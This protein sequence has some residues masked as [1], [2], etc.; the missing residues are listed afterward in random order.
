M[1]QDNIPTCHGTSPHAV[2]SWYVSFTTHASTCGFYV[3]PYFCFCPSTPSLMGFTCGHDTPG[4]AAVVGSS[5]ILAV[6]A[7]IAV[8]QAMGVAVVTAIS[9]APAIPVV[10]FVPA[11]LSTQHDLPGHFLPKLDT[12]DIQIYTALAK[13]GVYL[14]DSPQAHIL[15]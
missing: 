4:T 3:H 14:K 10:P 11:I 7:V 5:F 13:K 12:M 2:C 15:V 8:P 1:F 9:T 6:P